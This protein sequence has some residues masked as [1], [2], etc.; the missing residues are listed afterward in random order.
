MDVEEDSPTCDFKDTAL[1]HIRKVIPNIV[2]PLGVTQVPPNLGDPKHGKLKASEWHSLFATYLPLSLL[3]FFWDD[4]AS[5]PKSGQAKMLLNF[6]SLVICTNIVSKKGVTNRNCDELAEAYMLYSETAKDVFNSPKVTPN[7]HYALHLPDQLRWWGPLANV[8]EFSGERING[9]LQRI[10]TNGL[11]GKMEGTMMREFC[12]VQRFVSRTS[13]WSLHKEVEQQAGQPKRSARLVEV[14]PDFY[15]AMF[16]KLRFEDQAL[17]NYKDGPHGDEANVLS[18]Y[19]TQEAS[20]RCSGNLYI[21]KS[22]Q[23]RMVVYHKG[24]QT[25]HG[26]VT[27]IYGLPDFGGR[28]LV[29]VK[30][31]VE[32]GTVG[33]SWVATLRDLGLHLTQVVDDYEVLDPCEVNGVCAYRH[34]PAWTFRVASPLVLLRPI[35]RDVYSVLIK[36]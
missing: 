9:M 17:R 23:N 36:C 13:G 3:D 15:A 6:S 7:H 12:Q 14:H 11:I 10:Q 18:R 22:K 8:S 35:P 1:L 31:M 20:V 27:H 25:H 34:L 24:G 28:I 21:S 29:G 33:E 16:E 32:M 30:K 26:I 4:P 2:V 5:G 19:V